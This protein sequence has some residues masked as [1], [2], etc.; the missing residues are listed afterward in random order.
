MLLVHVT[1]DKHYTA[2][3]CTIQNDSNKNFPVVVTHATGQY[4]NNLKA[5]AYTSGNMF[6]E[7]VGVEVKTPCC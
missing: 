1:T 5:E 4:I 3:F 7:R 6:G 2:E